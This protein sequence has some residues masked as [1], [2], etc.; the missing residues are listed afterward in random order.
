MDT[1]SQHVDATIGQTLAPFVVEHHRRTGAD[2]ATLADVVGG[3]HVLIGLAL[4][5]AGLP[6]VADE[7]VQGIDVAQAGEVFRRRRV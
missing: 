2:V 3:D 4:L 7:V 6:A 1:E 5:Y